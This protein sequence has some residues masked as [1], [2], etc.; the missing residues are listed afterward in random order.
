MIAVTVFII[1]ISPQNKTFYNLCGRFER[2][3]AR[4]PRYFVTDD[5]S[6]VNNRIRLEDDTDNDSEIVTIDVSCDNKDA[7]GH[8]IFV[9]DDRKKED[10]F[11]VC[12][13]EVFAEK[14]EESECGEPELSFGSFVAEESKNRDDKKIVYCKDGLIMID[15]GSG[16]DI[17][18]NIITCSHGSWN[19]SHIK[20]ECM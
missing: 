18:T 6:R 14:Q 3:V 16:E 4:E 5:E 8:Q 15:G 13:V 11:K 1:E 17:N 20:C 2:S 12:E 19:S 10:Y 7:V 9:R